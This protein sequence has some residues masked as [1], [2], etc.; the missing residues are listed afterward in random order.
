VVRRA[1]DVGGDMWSGV[2]AFCGRTDVRLALLVL[3]VILHTLNMIYA[4]RTN[5]PVAYQRF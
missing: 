2:K 5:Q 1:A 4:W 3:L